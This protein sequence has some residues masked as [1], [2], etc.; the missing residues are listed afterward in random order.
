MDILIFLALIVAIGAL[1]YFNRSSKGLDVNNDGK[2][3]LADAALAAKNTV[4]GVKRLADA[5]GD[6]KVTAKDARVVATKAKAAAKKTAAKAKTAV[7][8]AT[9]RRSK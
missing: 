2:V 5:D 3:D 4:A 1:I 6:G 8:A 9:K 7:K